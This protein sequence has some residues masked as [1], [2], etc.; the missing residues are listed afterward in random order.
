[1]DQWISVLDELLVRPFE[2]GPGG[3]LKPHHVD[4]K[5]SQDFWDDETRH[6]VFASVLAQ[7]EAK[8]AELARALT[9]RHGQPR[10]ID[11]RPWLYGVPPDEPGGSL[12]AYLAGWF[13]EIELWRVGDRGFMTEV[14]H[15]DKELPLQLMIVVG[16]VSDRRTA[17]R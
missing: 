2:V 13:F 3:R 4:L 14:G 12:F 17:I 5:V 1:V 8:R 7:F 16:D 11:L 9:L 15:W 6:E 10:R